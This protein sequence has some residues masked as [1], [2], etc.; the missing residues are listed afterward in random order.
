M[1]TTRS[2]P[3]AKGLPSHPAQAATTRLSRIKNHRAV[4][5]V[6]NTVSEP[7]TDETIQETCKPICNEENTNFS[8]IV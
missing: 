3:D 8:E 7:N 6:A 2:L 5:T 4:I 1:S